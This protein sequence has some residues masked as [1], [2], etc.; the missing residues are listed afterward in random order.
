ME[1]RDARLDLIT[2]TACGR[3]RVTIESFPSG[4]T[5]AVEDAARSLGDLAQILDQAAALARQLAQL[6]LAREAAH[7]R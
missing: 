4:Q 7:G 1:A 3:F 6:L 2:T 5:I